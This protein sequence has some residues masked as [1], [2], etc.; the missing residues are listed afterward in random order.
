M[1]IDYAKC[2]IFYDKYIYTATPGET[3]GRA[4]HG[5]IA[6]LYLLHA[7]EMLAVDLGITLS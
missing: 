4:R 6:Q 2:S 5:L 3:M 1:G 7:P